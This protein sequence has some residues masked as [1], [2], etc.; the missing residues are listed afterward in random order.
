MSQ[1]SIHE[2]KTQLSRLI[3][4]ALAGEEVIIAKAGKPVVRLVPI[5]QVPGQ[6][7]LGGWKGTFRMATDFDQTPEGFEEYLP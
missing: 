4:R 1:S 5:E 3:Q 6:R 2:A 7:Q